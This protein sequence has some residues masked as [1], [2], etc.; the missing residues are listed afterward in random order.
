MCI[1]DRTSGDTS[2]DTRMMDSSAS[3]LTTWRRLEVMEGSP[4]SGLIRVRR[5][6]RR[7]KGSPTSDLQM[8]RELGTGK[9]S[10]P[11]TLGT[12]SP[13]WG[14]QGKQGAEVSRQLQQSGR[15]QGVATGLLR[16]QG[17]EVGG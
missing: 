4:A 8:M 3:A 5:K 1:R 14:C 10:P 9:V 15:Q 13:W 16:G 6:P 2:G 7:M 12:A 17:A 11:G